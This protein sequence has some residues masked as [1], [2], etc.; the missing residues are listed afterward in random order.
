MKIKGEESLCKR[1]DSVAPVRAIPYFPPVPDDTPSLERSAR[2]HLFRRRR[3][4]RQPP[5]PP[6]GKRPLA[7]VLIVPTE[8]IKW[9]CSE[10]SE[11][12]PFSRTPAD[13]V[14][15]ISVMYT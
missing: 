4:S 15:T 7:T 3:N 10:P 6:R 1:T 12:K 2:R 5:L 9:R 13:A 11:S 8:V 14:Y